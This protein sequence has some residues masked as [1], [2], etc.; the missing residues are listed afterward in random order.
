MS[1]IT[2]APD[3]KAIAAYYE[4]LDAL[5]KGLNL[6][7]EGSTRRA[8]SALLDE[9]ARVRKWTLAEEVTRR[10]KAHR[11]R[12]DGVLYGPGN[13]P[14]GFWEAKDE[15]DDLSAEILKKKAREYPVGN[16][17]FE[18]T[19]RAILIQENQEVEDI[20]LRNRDDLARLLTRFYNYEMAPFE[21]FD[22]AVAWF[23]DIIPDIGN[24]LKAKIAASHQR[25]PRFEREFQEFMALCRQSLNPNISQEA[26]DEMLIQHL[27]TERLIRNIFQGDFTRRNV[28]ANKVED[29]ISALTQP[30]FDRA[31]FQASLD[32]FYKVIEEAA[33]SLA[34][35]YQEKQEFI[36][37]VYEQFFQGYSVK[38][39]DTHGIVYTPQEIVDF[40][41]AAVEEVLQDEFGKK[42]GQAGVAVLDPCVG[43]GNFIINLLNRVSP[44]YRRD[45]YQHSLFANEVMLMP[46]YIASLNIEHEYYVLE[47]QYEPFEGISFVDTLDLARKQQLSFAFMTE[48]NSQRVQRQQDTD[49][50]VIIGNP[51]YNVGQQNEMDNN[52]NRSYEVIDDRLSKTY[53]SDSRATLRA[54]LYDAYIKF[55][56]WASDRL[57]GNDGIVCFITNNNFVLDD[58]FNGMRKHLWQ[59]FSRIYH[60]DLHGNVRQNPKL[61][62][63][64]H[65]VFKIQTGVG[66]TVAIRSSNIR[67]KKIFYY[68]VDEMWRREQK[69]HYLVRNATKAGIKNPLSIIDWQSLQPNDRNDWIVPENT[70]EFLDFAPM[71]TDDARKGRKK[72]PQVIFRLYANGTKTNRDAVV[73]DYDRDAL[74]H[75]MSAFAEHYNRTVDEYKRKDV[76]DVDE[77]VDYQHVKWSRNLKRNMRNG[78]YLDFQKTSV[79]LSMYRPYSKKHVYFDRI[80]IDELGQFG[81]FLPN[82]QEEEENK[83]ICVTNHSQVPFIAQ[84]VNQ[85]PEVAVGGRPGQCFPFYVYD[86]DGSNRR[87]NITDWALAQFRA[88]YADDTITKW[89]IFYYVYG[90]LH[91]PAYRTRYADTLKRELPRIP[92]VPNPPLNLPPSTEGDFNANAPAGEAGRG[93][94]S[95]EDLEGGFWAFSEA[96]KKLADLHLNYETAPRYD[97]VWETN[98]NVKPDYRVQKMK[99]RNKRKVDLGEIAPSLA[100]GGTVSIYDTLQYNDYLTITGIPESAFAY[101]LGN[102][103]ALDWIVDQYRVKTDK[104]SGITSDPNSYSDDDQYIV[105]LLERVIHISV[106][107]VS[108]VEKL[109]QLPFRVEG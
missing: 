45:F 77:F 20:D 60:L 61:S 55:F 48:E 96:G 108:L 37:T 102:R 107:T 38:A 43:T 15:S 4:R 91:H 22:K 74:V 103:S 106:E 70:Q 2:I 52:K 3:D 34:G 63:T 23:A 84:I 12:L 93:S 36:N 50:T 64:K 105:K 104:R 47:G 51:P 25:N 86:E 88:H 13:L 58:A 35:N 39:A 11:I 71:G 85:I 59:D 95:A 21:E 99:P 101:R 26:V 31:D 100:G 76:Q 29:V 7:S 94:T 65:N 49:I 10:R 5:K 46:Y 17:I 28:I 82:E 78:R 81:T 92:F 57:K 80:A 98:A 66:I 19:E 42:L 40:M 16:I 6:T 89:D 56:R 8:F 54:Q 83:V 27:L 73:F 14:R 53:V 32:T 72:N 41:C 44:R 109:A 75:R 67:D 33:N 62:G 97:V 9:T 1:A 87:E 69:L 30:L 79:R 68:R 24:S 18:D 90:L